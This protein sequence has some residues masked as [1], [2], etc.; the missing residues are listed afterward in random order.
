M[1]DI[2]EFA[3]ALRLGIDSNGPAESRCVIGGA[4]FPGNGDYFHDLLC[5][6]G[7]DRQPS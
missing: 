6:R 7:A 2:S 5:I 1:S 3:H 4:A